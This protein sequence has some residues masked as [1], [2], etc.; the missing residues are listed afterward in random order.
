MR[1]ATVKALG[2]L[3]LMLVAVALSAAITPTERMADLNKNL[4]LES[5]IPKAFGDWELVSHQGAGVVNPQQAELIESLYSQT[6]TRTYRN[7]RGDYIMLSIA[8]GGEQAGEIEL[9]RPE[10]CYVAQ[11]F[12][13]KP[14]GTSSVALPNHQ[15]T[16][17]LQRLLAR[18]GR[19]IE[20]ITYWMRV[21]DYV[22][23]SGSG[24]QLA[25]VRHGL[26]G[27]VPDGVLFRVSSIGSDTEAAYGLQDQFISELLE[28]LNLPTSRFLV[29]PITSELRQES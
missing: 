10:V 21:G 19:R 2:A 25:R 5:A 20:P 12:S 1:T 18:Q 29:G 15:G 13:L 28:A 23:A 7:S 26:R 3:V 9:H 22:L 11:G 14:N 24:Q 8:Y 4:K 27:W 6:L 16:L 17:P